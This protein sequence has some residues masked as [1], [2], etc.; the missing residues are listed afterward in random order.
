MLIR[1]QVCPS[2]VNYMLNFITSKIDSIIYTYKQKGGWGIIRAIIRKAGISLYIERVV[3]LYLDLFFLA[4][5]KSDASIFKLLDAHEIRKQKN[6]YDG[7]NSRN[8]AINKIVKGD[9]L[10]VHERDGK[11]VYFVWI[12]QKS[13]SIDWFKFNLPDNIAYLSNEFTRPEYR[14]LGIAKMVRKQIFHYLKNSG[15]RFIILVV[16][17]KN[18]KALNL[19]KSFGFEE[20]QSLTYKSIFYLRFFEIRSAKKDQVKKFIR[21]I[22][23]IENVWKVYADFYYKQSIH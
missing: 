19:N 12:E 14:G 11:F 23:P 1:N 17:P 15:I 20:Y 8:Q 5:S 7:F 22:R 9:K 21:F 16:N 4:D 6:Y 13:I 2:Y 3:F 18:E 10:F